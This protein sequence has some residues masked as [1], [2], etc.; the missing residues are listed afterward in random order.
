VYNGGT[1]F[2]LLLN[3]TGSDNVSP[4]CYVFQLLTAAG[5]MP[6]YWIGDANATETPFSCTIPSF[7]QA[8]TALL[9]WQPAS[10]ASPSPSPGFTSHP[11][12]GGDTPAIAGGVVGG[13][14]GLGLLGAGTYY[15]SHR[16]RR[17]TALQQSLLAVGPEQAAVRNEMT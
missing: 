13:L 10:N 11:T 16:R 17:Q 2:T 9:T 8:P 15:L 5:S 12:S 6:V 14:A 1:N 7:A 3:V 4:M